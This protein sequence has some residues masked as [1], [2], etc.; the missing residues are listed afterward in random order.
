MFEV[1]THY[2]IAP[3]YQF[4]VSVNEIDELCPLYGS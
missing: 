2:A 4:T 1:G 3:M